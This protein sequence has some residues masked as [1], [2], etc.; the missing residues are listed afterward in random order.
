MLRPLVNLLLYGHFWIAAAALAMTIQTHLLL[1]GS[2]HW[3]NLDAFI[4][5]GTLT[6]YALHRMV[7]I[8]IGGESPQEGRFKI[9]QDFRWHI[10]AYAILAAILAA[11]FYWQLPGFLKLSLLVP[12]LI[13][14]GY[15][16]PLL[17]GR[18]LRDLPYLKIFLIALSWAWITVIA[19]AQSMG[20]SLDRSIL[21]M[22]LERACFIFAITIPF[23][24]RDMALDKE[25][26][27]S[28]LPGQWGV[29]QAKR[30]AL[31]ALVVMAVLVS[32]NY[33]LDRYSFGVCL[34]LLLS[35][36]SSAIL[37]WKATPEKHDY[38]F[39]GLLDGTMIFQFGLVWLLGFL[40]F[41]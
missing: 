21:L 32:F 23:D 18:R 25:A 22:A 19:P 35:A 3:S 11:Y 39:T 38:Y 6:I 4:A 24:I 20:L 12:N 27:V 8:R 41:G 17:N 2:W 1:E 31:A 5:S 16:L 40:F 33:W 28:T 14:L 30:I 36:V 7:A 15:V 37:I 34:G 10:I 26:A 13:A 9:M 29:L